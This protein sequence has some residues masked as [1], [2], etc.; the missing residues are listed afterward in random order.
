MC[1][2]DGQDARLARDNEVIKASLKKYDEELER[3]I[4]VLMAQVLLD[5]RYIEYAC[6]L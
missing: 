5:N 3:Y 4:P 1:T 2:V 6:I